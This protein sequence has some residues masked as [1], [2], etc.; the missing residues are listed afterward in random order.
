[1]SAFIFALAHAFYMN[2]VAVTLSF[3]GGIFFAWAYERTRSFVLFTP[4]LGI[5][6]YHGVIPG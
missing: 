5:Y 1:M 6:F 3:A 2:W 4:G